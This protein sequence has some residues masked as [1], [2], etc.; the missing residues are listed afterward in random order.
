MGTFHTLAAF[1]TQ[2]PVPHPMSRALVGIWSCP[3]KTCHVRLELSCCVNAVS[4]TSL[5]NR[6]SYPNKDQEKALTDR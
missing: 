5:R 3:S 2:L 4:H 6:I 1:K